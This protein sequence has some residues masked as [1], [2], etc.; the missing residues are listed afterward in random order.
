MPIMR[1]SNEEIDWVE[2]KCKP[3]IVLSA[4]HRINLFDGYSRAP[5]D[6]R[7]IVFDSVFFILN[8]FSTYGLEG[9]LWPD[10]ISYESIVNDL[11]Y[12]SDLDIDDP[13]E[14]NEWITFV[15]DVQRC[16]FREMQALQI[17]KLFFRKLSLKELEKK[18]ISKL[19]EDF[20]PPWKIEEMRT[21]DDLFKCLDEKEEFDENC[22]RLQGALTPF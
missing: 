16:C 9:F 13:S 17:A 15:K 5:K 12:Y 20:I 1:L 22:R 10:E 7:E 11:L 4:I 2:K 3:T 6:E 18:I 21:E 8:F 14:Y 19:H